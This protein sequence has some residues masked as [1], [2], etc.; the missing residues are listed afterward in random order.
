[1]FTDYIC[2]TPN[3]EKVDCFSKLSYYAQD[4]TRYAGISDQKSFDCSIQPEID[5]L[6]SLYASWNRSTLTQTDLDEIDKSLRSFP[7]EALNKKIKM[8][9]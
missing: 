9:I 8:Q 4:L 7:A 1:M 2:C 3:V 6:S 5:F